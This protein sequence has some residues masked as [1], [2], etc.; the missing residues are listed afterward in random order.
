[1][2]IGGV[3]TSALVFSPL[4]I[5]P[6]RL[7]PGAL[8]TSGVLTV[9]G[10]QTV[11]FAC[12]TKVFGEAEGFLPPDPRFNR[13]FRYVN[14]ERGLLAGFLL[15]VGGIV[16]GV[17]AYAGWRNAGWGQEEASG[18]IRAVVPAA[19]GLVLGAQTVLSSFFV[20]ILGLGRVGA[21]PPE[22]PARE[23][24]VATSTR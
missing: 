20:S 18:A 1:M 15:V 19:L 9:I 23:P 10:H 6:V 3:L 7:G 16:G 14:L 13:V 11:L 2:V 5:G 24:A 4:E 12:L 22:I 17:I 21:T 8:V